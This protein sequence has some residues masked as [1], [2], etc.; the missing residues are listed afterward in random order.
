MVKNGLFNFLKNHFELQ[1]LELS[2]TILS[3]LYRFENTSKKST[4]NK[5]IVSVKN[6]TAISLVVYAVGTTKD[7]ESFL[8][9]LSFITPS[10]SA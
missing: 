4:F 6:F 1:L 3:I 9:I 2:F 10:N 7:F 5:R 8:G